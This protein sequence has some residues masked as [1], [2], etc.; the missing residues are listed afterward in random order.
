MAYDSSFPANDSFLADF[1]PGMRE[2]IRALVQDMV[3]NALKLQGLTPGNASGNIPVANG[4]KCTNLN[5]E[6]H[7]GNLPSA[8]ATAGHTHSAVTTSTNGFMSNTDK[9]KL[10]GIAVGAEVNQNAF[11]NITVGSTTIQA[12]SET[13]TLTFTAGTGITLTPNATTDSVAIAVTQDGHIHTAATTGSA[14]FMSAA[15]KAKL[16]AIAAGAEVNQNAFTTIVAGGVSAAADSESDT[17]TINAG[18]GIT[19]TGDATNDACTIAITANGHTHSEATTSAAG[20]M[21]AAMVTK[22]NGIATGAQVNQNAFSNILVETTTVAADSATDTLELVAGTNIALTPD[23]TNDR[24]TIGITGKVASASAADSATTA[25]TAGTCTGNA[26]TA[27]ILQTARTIGINGD[28]TGTATSFN[29]GTNITIPLVL[30]ASGVAAGTY[31]SVT[32]DAKGRVTAA[33]NPTTI[34]ASTTGNAATA[35]KLATA[36]NINGVAFDGT[37]DINIPTSYGVQGQ[38]KN[39]KV[40]VTSNTAATITAD[41]IVAYSSNG[42]AALLSNVNVT[43]STGTTGVNGRDT[44][45]LTANTWYYLYV[46]YN[47][48]TTTVASLMSTSSTAPTLP[49][50]YTYFVR[51]GSVLTN[52]SSY[53]YRTI[54]RGNNTQYVLDGTLLTNYPLLVSG[55]VGSLTAYSLATLIPVAVASEVSALLTSPPASGNAYLGA[56]GVTNIIYLLNNASGSYAG[57]QIQAQIVL[58]TN[59]LYY[60]G[61]AAQGVRI[62]GWRDNL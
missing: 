38:A 24:V 40:Q 54:Q 45:S 32:V 11:S 10:D 13:D 4:T 57:Q 26:A 9:T 39:L 37:A 23:A 48:T 58:E 52:A 43:L 59:Y 20:F 53:L 27:T 41:Q 56:N 55:A 29:G 34:S 17:F 22:L 14:G 35:T 18:S 12:D 28:A 30:A 15:D 19:V 47:P 5:A 50:G 2:Q 62:S 60:Q 46:I 6:L 25:T 16:D 42:S 49:S 3:V 8:Y 1:P 7:G 36:R 21:P 44:G 31:T 33:S 51:V 61:G